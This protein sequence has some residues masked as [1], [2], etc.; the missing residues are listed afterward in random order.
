ML[1][2]IITYQTWDRL[3]SSHPTP[4]QF[5]SESRNLTRTFTTRSRNWKFEIFIQC[6]GFI[7]FNDAKLKQSSCKSKSKE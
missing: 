7:K 5:V 4:H 1:I 2:I 6:V 3:D